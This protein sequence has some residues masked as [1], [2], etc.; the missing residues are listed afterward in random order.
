MLDIIRN[1]VSSIFGKVLLALMVLSFALWG[2]GDILTSGNSRL[3]AK[4]GDEKISLEDFYINFQQTLR[5]IS[6]SSG[7]NISIQ[8]AKDQQLDKI[9]LNEMIYQ[10]MITDFAKKQGLIISDEV[11]KQYIMTMDEFKN[12]SGKFNDLLYKNYIQNNFISESAFLNEMESILLRNLLFENF[13]INNSINEDL[14]TILYNHEGKKIDIEYF[15]IDDTKITVN[16]NEDELREY[17]DNNNEKYRVPKREYVNYINVGFEKFKE[18]VEVSNFDLKDFYDTNIQ[19][20]TSKESRDVEFVRVPT[21]EKAL[22]IAQKWKLNKNESFKDFAANNDFEIFEINDLRR[23]RFSEDVTNKI[24]NLNLNDISDSIQIA[25]AGF[26]IFKITNVTKE[27]VISFD[28]AKSEIEE[29]LSNQIAYELYDEYIDEI[30]S[31]LINGSSFDEILT[32]SSEILNV[33]VDDLLYQNVDYS[34]LKDML[35]NNVTFESLEDIGEMSDLI[36]TDTSMYIYEISSIE[37]SF[38]KKF[39]NIINEITSDLISEKK[40]Q[41]IE[42]IINRVLVELQFTGYESF[43]DF[44]LSENYNLNKISNLDRNNTNESKLTTI[45]ISELFDVGLNNLSMIRTKDN[46]FGIAIVKKISKPEDRISS[47]F[48]EDV[49]ENVIQNYN[50]SLNSVLGNKIIDNTQYEIFT[51]N[52]ENILM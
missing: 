17:Y 3:A 16:V 23:D 43:R 18:L 14:I 29:E 19:N 27:A 39:E 6:N 1:L 52:I 5:D 50:N 32:Q 40:D 44:S 20:Y 51:Q 30:D 8:Q 41:E 25:D 34:D 45:S 2:V 9:M 22:D 36:L 15:T 33:N 11:L 35:N 48:F 26:Y 49:R 10:K 21:E 13:N 38:I 28:D 42:K 24:F 12:N 37:D 47:N 31:Q 7:M 4:V 46:Q